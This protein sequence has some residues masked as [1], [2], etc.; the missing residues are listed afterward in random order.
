MKYC[1]VKLKKVGFPS[2][3][4]VNYVILNI[5]AAHNIQSVLA[6]I[7]TTIVRHLTHLQP[8]AKLR[9]IFPSRGEMAAFAVG[10]SP[11]HTEP[12]EL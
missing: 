11:K 2:I 6:D 12:P 10:S 7:L 9:G 3:T 1:L 8:L 4:W 5:S